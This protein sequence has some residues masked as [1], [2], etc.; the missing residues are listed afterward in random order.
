MPCYNQNMSLKDD[1]PAPEST[2][3]L[4]TPLQALQ[5]I[6][7]EFDDQEGY[8]WWNCSQLARHAALLGG[9]AWRGAGFTRPMGEDRGSSLK[10]RK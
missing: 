8:Y 7:S 10:P 2:T 4:L 9:A 6:L 3:P 1:Q 5:N